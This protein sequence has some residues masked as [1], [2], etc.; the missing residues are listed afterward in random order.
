[1]ITRMD[2]LQSGKA[3]P[4]L[5]SKKGRN[6]PK[7][8]TIMKTP[9][10]TISND[11]PIKEAAKVIKNHDIGRLPVIRNEKLIGIVDREDIIEQY[12]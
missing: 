1:M 12:L 11:A 6:P 3:R 7:V 9:V 2:I 8:K 4:S 10:I 5:E